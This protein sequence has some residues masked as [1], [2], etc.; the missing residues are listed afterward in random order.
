MYINSNDQI[1][2]KCARTI[3]FV[4]APNQQ[5]AQNLY[6][7]T[8]LLRDEHMAAIFLMADASVAQEAVEV[9][10][11][12]GRKGRGSLIQAAEFD[13]STVYGDDTKQSQFHMEELPV[14]LLHVMKALSESVLD[15][16]EY[17]IVTD[18]SQ[19]LFSQQEI[20]ELYAQE[21]PGDFLHTP[22]LLPRAYLDSLE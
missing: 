3:A 11:K 16:Y 9:M 12:M 10:R 13:F 20:E 4:F 17:V 14:D 1:S 19:E 18:A 15:V 5:S 2:R 22:Y 6:E 21:N 7:T 8:S